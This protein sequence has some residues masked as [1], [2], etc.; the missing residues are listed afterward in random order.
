QRVEEHSVSL[1]HLK[2]DSV[3]AWIIVLDAMIHLVVRNTQRYSAASYLPFWIGVSLKLPFV[4]A[5]HDN[6]T[7]VL[8]VHSLHCRPRAH[9]SFSRTEREVIQILVHWVPGRHFT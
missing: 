3:A 7:P 5:W 6:Q 4:R 2:V 9:N 8:S 1:L